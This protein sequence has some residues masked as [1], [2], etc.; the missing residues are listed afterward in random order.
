MLLLEVANLHMLSKMRI[1]APQKDE[2]VLSKHTKVTVGP[3]IWWKNVFV[4]DKNDG[5]GKNIFSV[6]PQLSRKK[7]DFCTLSKQQGTGKQ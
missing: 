3:Q 2:N 6:F 7:L 1:L 5:C 4:H